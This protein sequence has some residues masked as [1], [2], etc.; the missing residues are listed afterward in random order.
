M[1]NCENERLCLRKGRCT[2]QPLSPEWRVVAGAGPATVGGA[3]MNRLLPRYNQAG[4]ESFY[5]MK[6]LIIWKNELV[7]SWCHVRAASELGA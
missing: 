3:L 4:F 7:A 2:A 5:L 6:Y 1:F